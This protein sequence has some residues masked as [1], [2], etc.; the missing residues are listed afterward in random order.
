[1]TATDESGGLPDKQS[2]SG[3]TLQGCLPPSFAMV[4]NSPTFLSPSTAVLL[5]SSFL[6]A[7]GPQITGV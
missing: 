1:M 7:H 4:Q 3:I 6:C 2:T 5:G